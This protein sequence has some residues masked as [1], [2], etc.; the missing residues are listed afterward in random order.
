MNLSPR[1]KA[2][3]SVR[4]PSVY[5]FCPAIFTLRGSTLL[6]IFSIWNASVGSN[7]SGLVKYLMV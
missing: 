3:S 4:R 2:A 7:G 6:T 1:K 5:R